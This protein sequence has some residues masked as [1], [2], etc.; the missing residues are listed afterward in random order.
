MLRKIRTA[1]AVVF[2]IGITL[3]LLDISGMLH[4]WLGWMAKVQLLPAVLAL[5]VAVIAGLVVLTLVLGRIYCSVICPLGV[6]QDGIAHLHVSWKRRK[7]DRK[8]YHY[9][10]ETKWLRYGVWVLFVAALIAGVQAAVALLAP[11]SAYGRIVQN[12]FQPVWVWGNNL[13]ASLAERAGSYAFYSREIW[14]RSLPTFVVAAVMLV[15]VGFLAW[16]GGRDYCNAV[17]PV[18]TTLS[19]LSR[20]AMFR[21]VIDNGKCKNCHVC[22]HHCKAS[23][24]DIKEHKIDY[25]RCVDCFNCLGACKFDALHY[26][27]AWGRATAGHHME[28]DKGG[29][30]EDRRHPESDRESQADQGRR[31][32]LTGTVLAGGTITLGAQSKKVD[33]GYAALLDKTVPQRDTPLTPPGSK[34]IRDFYRHCTACQLC[35]AACPNQVL[36]PSA[37]L[38]RFMQPE[39][40]YE[41]GYCRPECTR[42]S[43]VCPTGAIRRI[44]REEKT[45]YH[46][47]TARIDRDL[48]VAE[49]GTR[50]GNCARHCPAGAIT[51]VTIEDRGVRVPTV[52]TELCIGC[53]ACENHCPAR[54]V[55]AITVNGRYEHLK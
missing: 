55:S 17:C 8:P 50:C 45:Q 46:I 54:P 21:P 9:K 27:F 32:F 22:E 6:L 26:Q 23:C 53:G 35:V 4:G 25:S 42:C 16:R 40:S 7:K 15:V 19:F 13:L 30:P 49:D 14:L 37:D 31:A 51:M 11:Y 44:T 29:Q 2:F 20:F 47:G 1:L 38:S 5:N 43:E 48:C 24:I 10:K 3:L 33:G 18:G 28:T 36:R 41:R 12:L 34:G 39:M 52:N